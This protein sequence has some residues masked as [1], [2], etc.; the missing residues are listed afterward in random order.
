MSRAISATINPVLLSRQ[1]QYIEKFQILLS[2]QDQYMEK[3]QILLSRQE[4]YMEK[5]KILLH[6][7]NNTGFRVAG[8]DLRQKT[9]RGE[10]KRKRKTER[11]E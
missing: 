11:W 9:G 1:E 4:Q 6:A 8:I 5:F 7:Q 2:R 10:K 3:F